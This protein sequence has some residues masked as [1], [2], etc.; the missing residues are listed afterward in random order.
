VNLT[1]EMLDAAMRK[2]IEAGLLP[3]DARRE[4]RFGH[5]ELIGYV[6]R[7]AFEA[8][9]LEP[10]PAEAGCYRNRAIKECRE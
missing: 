4:D 3:R 6:L 2:A 9:R 1:E 10:I 5:R 8:G 7:G